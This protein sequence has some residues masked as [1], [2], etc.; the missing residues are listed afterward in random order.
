MVYLSEIPARFKLRKIDIVYNQQSQRII[1]IF[2]TGHDSHGVFPV[3]DSG[4][5]IRRLKMDVMNKSDFV[6]FH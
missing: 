3:Q 6:A 2:C 1:I 4:N 5:V